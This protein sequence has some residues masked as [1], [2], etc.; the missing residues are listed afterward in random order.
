MK[1]VLC[2]GML[3]LLPLNS[4]AYAMAKTYENCSLSAWDLFKIG[5]SY[6]AKVPIEKAQQGPSSHSEN[7]ARFYSTADKDGIEEAQLAAIGFYAFCMKDA[8][9]KLQKSMFEEEKSAY[10]ACG[11]AN[12]MNFVVLA[13]L[14]KGKTADELRTNLADVY[15]QK[16][17]LFSNLSKS[18]S[19]E[20]PMICSA[21]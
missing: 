12:A 20:Y 19:I 11:E 1:F 13:G 16:I 17:E 10:Y 15:E 6:S 8:K 21:V 14:K 3:C 2:L 5:D 18:H 9:S 7:V 4:S